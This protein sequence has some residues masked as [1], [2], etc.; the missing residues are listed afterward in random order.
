[1]R[2]SFLFGLKMS[3]AWDHSRDSVR[4]FI[5]IQTPLP[6]FDNIPSFRNCDYF[7]IFLSSPWLGVSIKGSIKHLRLNHTVP[8]SASRTDSFVSP[9]SSTHRNDLLTCRSFHSA[10]C[11]WNQFGKSSNIFHFKSQLKRLELVQPSSEVIPAYGPPAP[12]MLKLKVPNGYPGLWA[13]KFGKIR[14]TSTINI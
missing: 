11:T 6:Q 7:P 1:M 4:R 9:S 12:R 10:S 5:R 13:S 8:D 14:Y 2:L 3:A